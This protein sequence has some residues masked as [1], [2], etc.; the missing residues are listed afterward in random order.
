MNRGAI[1]SNRTRFAFIIIFMLLTAFTVANHGGTA[2]AET[3]IS[4]MA[5][6]KLDSALQTMIAEQPN[7]LIPVIVQKET[8][9]D[10][11]ETLLATL[12]GSVSQELAIVN[13]F[14]T[15]LSGEAILRL[16]SSPAVA[17]ISLDAQVETSDTT[18]ALNK[19]ENPGFESGLA[20]WNITDESIISGDAYSG[21]N[22]LEIKGEV[23]QH[24]NVTPGD[25]V[26]FSAWARKAANPGGNKMTLEFYNAHGYLLATSRVD[27]ES[28]IYTQY[29]IEYLV[30]SQAYYAIARVSTNRNNGAVLLDDASF[31]ITIQAAV[32]SDTSLLKNGGFE[33]GTR[34]W[35]ISGV[36][37]YTTYS[38]YIHTGSRAIE[39]GWGNTGIDQWTTIQPGQSYTLTGWYK[40]TGSPLSYYWGSVWLGFYDANWNYLTAVGANLQYS[41][42]YAP[43]ELSGVAPAQTKYLTVWM[44]KDGLVK[45]YADDLYLNVETAATTTTNM[46]DN[47]SFN[48]NKANWG[49]WGTS[50]AV[51]IVADSPVDNTS[52]KI[53]SS[54]GGQWRLAANYG[55][56]TAGIYLFRLAQIKQAQRPPPAT[57][58]SLCLSIIW[59]PM[60]TI[61]PR[62]P[63]KFM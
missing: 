24:V 35:N 14:A 22:A 18:S 25:T 39:L 32:A 52:L 30:P 50:S 6:L 56:P 48:N 15:E 29:N 10:E 20:G 4:E 8:D 51:T 46:L 60:T 12:G 9:T 34:Y 17:Y 61:C 47:G 13:A 1:R 54:W 2:V 38:K 43:L 33:S 26:L 55:Q 11:A 23:Y 19:L 21:S 53:D 44:G 3:S 42:E 36:T 63:T 40:M 62:F 49:T 37:R 45:M 57:P 31:V 16:A 7:Q 58:G 41:T 28:Q 59:T 27:I 5:Q